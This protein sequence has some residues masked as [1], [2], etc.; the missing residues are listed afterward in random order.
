MPAITFDV[1]DG[2][3]DVSKGRS[4]AGA[5][6]LRRLTNAYVTTGKAIRKRPGLVKVADLETGTKGLVGAGSKLHTFYGQGSI[7]HANSLFQANLVPHPAGGQDVTDVHAATSFNGYLYVAA[8]YGNGDTYHSY[9]DD[10]GAWAPNTAYSVGQ[11]RRPTTPNGYRYEVTVAGTSDPTT[12]P[13]WPTTIGATVTDGTTS[14][15]TWKCVAHEVRDANCP[16]TKAIAKAAQKIWAIDGEVV[17]FTATGAPRDWTTAQDAGFLPTGLQTGAEPDATALGV[18]RGFLAV[19]GASWLQV[20]N[21]DPD[22]AQHSLFDQVEGVGTEW[23]RSVANLSGDT[24][25]LSRLGFRSVT[26]SSTTNNLRDV[27]V[28]SAIDRLVRPL[29]P[30]ASTPIGLYWPSGG[31][32]LCAIGSTCWVYSFSRTAKLS[33]WSKYTLPAS[34]DA[35][36]TLDGELYIRAGDAVYRVDDSVYTDDGSIFTVDIALP[37][38]DFK[39]PGVLKMVHG[40]D[41]VMD[42]D[43]KLAVAYDARDESLTTQQVAVSGNT[44]PGD[45]TPVEVCATEL[46]FEVTNADDQAF[47]LQSLTAYYEPLGPV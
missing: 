22:P 19:F 15:V 3:L 17:R 9:L 1:F 20:W 2:G 23:P 31:Q 24:Y 33:A 8:E 4:V 6:Q 46:S 10:P 34:V 26:L 36:T 7:T 37:Y 38:M 39:Q 16:H 12:E 5:N 41:T 40:V 25:F 42:G 13:S 43:G 44:R 29:I 45:M 14:P 32:Y 27:D 28:G 18:F 47:E 11:F 21:I 30:P 35:M